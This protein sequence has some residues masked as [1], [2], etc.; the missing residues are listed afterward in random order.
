MR[1]TLLIALL[2]ACSQ[3]MFSRTTIIHNEPDS[4]YLFSYTTLPDEGRGGLKLAWSTDANQWMSIG[5]G[6]SF[7]KCDYGPWGHEKRMFAP[8]LYRL[9]DGSW[10]CT[11]Q[12]NPGGKEYGGATSAD[13]MSWNPQIYFPSSESSAYMPA[14][15]SAVTPQSIVLGDEALNGHMQKISLAELKALEHY[16][17]HRHY[18]AMLHDERTE[19]DA[20]RFANLNGVT[21]DIAVMPQ[22]TKPISD[23]LI[24][25]FFED[26]NYAADGGLYAELIQN[27]GFE[28]S[29]A[30]RG[31]W[32]STYAW[33]VKG[34]G[35]T[36]STDTVAPIH[37]NNPNYAILTVNQ[38]GAALINEGFDGIPVVKGD[39]YDFSV[40]TKM[41]QGKGGK[42]L[43]RLVDGNGNV[44]AQ[45]TLKGIS[46]DWKKQQVQLTAT[47]GSTSAVLEIIPE[48]AGS[49]GIDF[50]SLFPQKTYKNRKNGLRAD[51]AQT[52][53]GLNP[54]FVRFPGGCVAHGNGI[55]N[56]YHWKNT[57]GPVE[58]RKPMP[59]LW[60]YQQ[61]M[62]LGYHEYFQFCEDL[63]A[64][65][66]PV[67]AAGV[68]CQNSGHHH[69]GRA[70][71]AGQQGGIPMDEM[72]AYLQDIFDLIEYANGDAKKS[73]W[74]RK[75]A[76]N[77][78][79]KPFNLKYVGIGNEDLITDV[80]AERFEYLY[81]GVKAR[82]PEIV[83][84]GTVGPFYEGSDYEAGWKLATELDVPMVDEHYYNTPGWFIHNQDF[85]DRYDRNKSKVYLGEYA[86]HLPSRKSTIETALAEAL[87]LTSV[88]RNGD[89]VEM[90]SYAPLLAKENHTQWNPDL[91]YFNNTE[92][93]PTVGYYTQQM[94][95]Q[96]EGDTYVASRIK[97]NQNNDGVNKRIGSSI[98]TD[99][100]TGDAIIKLVNMLPVAVATNVDFPMMDGMNP[101]A[102]TTILTGAPDS[103]TALP[104]QGE[105]QVSE[106][107]AYEMPAYSFTVIRVKKNK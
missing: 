36:L 32:H 53:E 67:V 45:T 62:G 14:I 46:S 90:T 30:D 28:Y 9:D 68:P 60:G 26:I 104:V 88:E 11:W 58:A 16:V 10:Y 21:A 85:Y 102:Q 42:L 27:R 95:G 8:E 103:T 97:T 73:E 37:P 96:N 92:V 6:Y 70:C 50:V 93:K 63:G 40:Y 87:F 57:I 66:V 69:D 51:L 91:I 100:K 105:M 99:A 41:M 71:G 34:N 101:T 33:Q 74:G 106:N 13:L 89:V 80:F 39:K 18:R 83:V 75:R 2:A 78:H 5:N 76:A 94:Y 61:S 107:F 98:V 86:A 25:I 43:V 79:P 4:V 38:P 48:T 81:N 49:Y 19:S 17:D 59:N 52:L 24:G 22:Q 1:K 15:V 65:P 23:K 64:I 72:G 55:E 82:Y 31:N 35:M 7:L 77:G 47:A 44:L 20:Q 54:Q 56:I 29:P 12:L 3:P 84:I